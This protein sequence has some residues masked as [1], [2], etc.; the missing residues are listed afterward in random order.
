MKKHAILHFK[1]AGLQTLVQDKGRLGYQAFGVPIS[2]A[3][4]Q[5]SAQIANY[6]VDNPPNAPVLELTLIG[7]SIEVEGDCQI[8][9]VG[10]DLSL[11]INRLEAPL[12]ETITVK[13]GDFISFGKINKGCRAYIA[14][15][16]TWSI[17]KWLGSYSAATSM[18]LKLTPDSIIQKNSR[19]FIKNQKPIKKRVY[20]LEKRP[21]FP[22]SIRVRVLPGPEFEAFSPYTIG[23]FFSR[24][25]QLTSNS[26]RMGYRLNAD[27]IDFHPH[28]EVISSAIVPG[29]IQISNAGQ[30]IILMADAQTVGGYFRL[31]NVLSDDLD[32]LAQLKPGDEVWFSLVKLLPH[33]RQ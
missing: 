6:L 14:I 4:D 28:R 3:L 8:A 22:T 16:G 13:N 10:A 23:Y 2:G 1:K 21:D 11:K 20:P 30:P 18:G 12:Y 19:I 5:S 33:Y 26:N 27:L 7:P 31:A 32:K 9:V 15:R 17:K 29:T 25:Y 24:G